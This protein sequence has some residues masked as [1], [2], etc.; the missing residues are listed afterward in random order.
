MIFETRLQT[1]NISPQKV[2]Q[3]YNLVDMRLVLV[4]LATFLQS[5]FNLFNDKTL[6]VCTHCTTFANGNVGSY[7][8]KPTSTNAEKKK[9]QI[10]ILVSTTATTVMVRDSL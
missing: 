6:F 1:L 7:R 5:L 8:I 4:L 3:I 10:K 2:R 9:S